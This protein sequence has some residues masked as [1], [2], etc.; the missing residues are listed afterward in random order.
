MKRSVKKKALRCVAMLTL[1]FILS[2][3]LICI[4]GSFFVSAN[5]ASGNET[6]HVRL[7]LYEG[8]LVVGDTGNANLVMDAWFV[9]TISEMEIDRHK[10]QRDDPLLYVITEDHS[11]RGERFNQL[12]DNFGKRGPYLHVSWDSN[13]T[14]SVIKNRLKR[15]FD[16]RI[17]N[18]LANNR[19]VGQIGSILFIAPG[20]AI[21]LVATICLLIIVR[22]RPFP[23][24][25]CQ[26]C[27]Y[28]LT[29][30]TTGTCPEC[31]TAF[32]LTPVKSNAAPQNP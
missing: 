6:K 1:I 12:I 16:A 30:N 15:C 32:P 10:R 7:A 5:I 21:V 29:N 23:P 28:N 4:C 20:W 31:G 25:H 14:F 11:G 2:V 17:D 8:T 9:E 19:F 13:L 26:E 22:T 27:N 3:S 24:G 18:P